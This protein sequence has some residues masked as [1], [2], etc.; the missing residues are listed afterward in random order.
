MISKSTK[1][2]QSKTEIK[3]NRNYDKLKLNKVGGEIKMIKNAIST[4]ISYKYYYKNNSILK[5]Q[6]INN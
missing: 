3:V 4:K 6:W 2:T 5:Q 1:I